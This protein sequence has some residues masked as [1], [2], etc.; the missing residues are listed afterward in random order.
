MSA[1][2][3]KGSDKVKVG[4]QTRVLNIA[5]TTADPAVQ[6]LSVDSTFDILRRALTALAS[7]AAPSPSAAAPTAAAPPRGRSW[8][9]VEGVIDNHMS[10]RP[11]LPF[12]GTVTGPNFRGLQATAAT[13]APLQAL[14]LDPLTAVDNP[15][16]YDLLHT[17]RNLPPAIR[18][19][20]Y[21]MKPN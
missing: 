21:A 14:T 11:H 18:E 6:A 16:Y 17:E 4:G 19:G 20:L 8:L 7:P 10:S 15:A 1:L 12:Q 5:Q 3:L 9:A 13:P 2:G